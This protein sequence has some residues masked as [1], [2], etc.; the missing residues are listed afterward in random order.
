M[1]KRIITFLLFILLF[2]VS[3][4]QLVLAQNDY[5]CAVLPE[6]ILGQAN[7]RYAGAANTRYAGAAGDTEI[8]DNSWA[9]EG[10]DALT[11]LQYA[12]TGNEAV[13]II[14]ID[15]FSTVDPREDDTDDVDWINASHGWLVDEVFTIV[16]D[17]LPESASNLISIEHLELGGDNE[18]QTDNLALELE[19]L[20]DDLH[21]NQGIDN[22][23]VNMSFVFVDCDAQG[24][25]HA[26]WLE[27]RQ[28]NPDLT[29]VEEA[30]G[31][32]DYL[33]DVLEDDRVSRIDE[34][35]FDMDNSR[36]GQGGPPEFVANN[37][38]MLSLFE[39]SRMNND[40]L[41]SFFMDSHPY[42]IVP[43][44]SS[45]NFKWKRPFFPA[46]WNEVLSVSATL[47]DSDDLWQLSNNGEVSAPG[48]YFLF[49]DDTYRAG[50]SFAA[51]VVSVMTALDLTNSNPT[52]TIA[53]NG[54]AELSSNGRWNDLPLNDAVADRC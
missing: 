15:D 47:G 19:S 29:L 49:D 39:V 22:F 35:G 7:T 41:R 34:N 48:A 1:G 16:L 51:P 36:N 54:Q 31:D 50:T 11:N 44:A 24:F 2:S 17:T 33:L 8:L 42:T 27:R 38:Q 9:V 3:T 20:L 45:G 6:Q 25:N 13:A 18:F 46:Q 53:R 21:S 14:V 4:S 40:P 28:N 26:D 10:T 30:G 43:I 5:N 52:C 23:V 37:L 32:I 12:T